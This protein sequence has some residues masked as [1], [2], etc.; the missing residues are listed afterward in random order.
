M[1]NNL[2]IIYKPIEELKVYANNPRFNDDAVQYVA[3]SIKQFGF[4]VPMVIDK[5]NVIVARTY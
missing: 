2:E 1:K 5:D 4:K 3:N